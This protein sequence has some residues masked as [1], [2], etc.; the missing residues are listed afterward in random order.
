MRRLLHILICLSLSFSAFSQSKEELQRQRTLLQDQIDL[1]NTILAN[2]KSSKEASLS[3][4][5]TLNEKISTR[6]KLISTMGRQI[7]A[8][9][10]S[11]EA[12]E[13]EIEELTARV[14]S[15][16][17]D[18]A[19]LIRL[20]QQQQEPTDQI[21]FILSSS[22]FSQ[23]AKRLQYFRDMAGYRAQQVARISEVQEEL[24]KEK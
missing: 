15:L 8:I 9:D 17:E 4:L 19:K 21:L 11:I 18:Y 20:A 13:K 22:S 23:A 2:T 7:R 12:K 6:E 10:K 14:D 1:A 24:A 16:K 5:E 3:E